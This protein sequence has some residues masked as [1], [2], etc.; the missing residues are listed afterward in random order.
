[1]QSLQFLE[2]IGKPVKAVAD[3]SEGDIVGKVHSNNDIRIYCVSSVSLK[4]RPPYFYPRRPRA[5][6]EPPHVGLVIVGEQ[7]V[8]HYIHTPMPGESYLYSWA[9]QPSPDDTDE[10]LEELFPLYSIDDPKYNSLGKLIL[11]MKI[12]S[13]GILSQTTEGDQRLRDFVASVK[14]DIQKSWELYRKIKVAAQSV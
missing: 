1:M 8:R 4:P 9:D 5:M 6:F 10:T 3:L 14:E 7:V 13:W 12:P 2:K 11:D